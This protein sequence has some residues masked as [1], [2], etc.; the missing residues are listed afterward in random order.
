MARR[1]ALLVLKEIVERV[2]QLLV[3]VQSANQKLH[4]ARRAVPLPAPLCVSKRGP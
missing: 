1:R 2:V 3:L 4:V